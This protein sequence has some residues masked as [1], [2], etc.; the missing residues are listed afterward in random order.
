MHHKEKVEFIPIK[1]CLYDCTQHQLN[2]STSF[3][4]AAV[5]LVD[6]E[7]VFMTRVG[8]YEYLRFRHYSYIV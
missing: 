6:K 5:E 4:A 8:G 1:I 7:S 3:I 2:R